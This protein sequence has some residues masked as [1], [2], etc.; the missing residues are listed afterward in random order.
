MEYGIFYDK[1]K[2]VWMYQ[3]KLIHLFYDDGYIML[4][5]NSDAAL[6]DGLS[7]KVIRNVDGGIEGFAEMTE[8]EVDELFN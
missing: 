5:D 3:D 4:A 7:L 8:T 2:E 1:V 6:K